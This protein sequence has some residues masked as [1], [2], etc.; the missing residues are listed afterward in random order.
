MGETSLVLTGHPGTQL[1]GQSVICRFGFITALVVPIS[2]LADRMK[3]V[4][5]QIAEPIFKK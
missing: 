4:L 1:V 2:Q 5:Q 3:E